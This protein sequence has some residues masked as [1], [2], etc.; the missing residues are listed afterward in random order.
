MKIS[1]VKGNDEDK[2]EN[3]FCDYDSQSVT[4]DLKMIF[5]AMTLN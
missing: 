1:T 4:Q 2:S 5:H 3:L